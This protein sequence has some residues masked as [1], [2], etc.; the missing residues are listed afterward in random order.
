MRTT[1]ST[2][3]EDIDPKLTKIAANIDKAMLGAPVM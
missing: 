3:M 1:V 2:L